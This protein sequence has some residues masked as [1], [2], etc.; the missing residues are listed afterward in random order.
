VADAHE[1]M[2]SRRRASHPP[3]PVSLRGSVS[4][5]EAALA[6]ATPPATRCESG[7]FQAYRY[8]LGTAKSSFLPRS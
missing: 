5:S 4:I 3:P 6:P 2:L 1:A 8:V 7:M